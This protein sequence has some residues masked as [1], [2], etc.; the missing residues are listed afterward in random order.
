MKKLYALLLAASLA[1][2][3]AVPAFADATPID[4]GGA[5]TATNKGVGDYSIGV[6]G[7]HVAG[8][9]A[10]DVV[11]VD[12]SWDAMSFTYTAGDKTY[13]AG[14]HTTTTADGSWSTDKKAITVKN[15]SNV[16]IDAGFSF[17]GADGITGTFY[18]KSGDGETA[19]YT[20]NTAKKLSLASGEDKTTDTEIYSLPTAS[21]YFGVSGAA[22]TED[23]T[24]GTITV[25]IAKDDKVYTGEELQA[26]LDKVAQTGGT[27]KLGA[28][29][30][31]PTAEGFAVY[32][33][34]LG[35]GTE[36]TLDLNGHT[37]TGVIA[38]YNE[39][40][41]A[42]G[43][44][45]IKNGTIQYSTET[46]LDDGAGVITGSNVNIEIDNVT[47]NAEGFL[48]AANVGGNMK[49]KDSTLNGGMMISER[50]TTVWTNSQMEFSGTVSVEN[51]IGGAGSGT[52]TC[53]AGTYNFD[54]TSYVDTTAYT[55]T[56][57]GDGTWT[58]A[59]AAAE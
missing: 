40:S 50:L 16:R 9:A 5:T 51:A 44:L 53:L 26:A 12:I 4:G 19:T 56:D 37:V 18:D 7:T 10:E 43:K 3:A 1:A 46:Q 58:V 54:P 24:L 29:V 39:G 49:I 25:N 23:T 38:A 47:V 52:L 35:S 33:I 22:I 28:D 45:F 14:S 20:E 59:V 21:I 11:S 27:V 36:I 6:S 8:T 15:H 57:N 42:A 17:A 31:L 55:V 32:T 48:A 2:T 34:A 13:H 30:T 41:N